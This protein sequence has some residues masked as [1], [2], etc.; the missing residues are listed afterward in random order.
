[1]S[2]FDNV[3]MPAALTPALVRPDRLLSHSG[4]I[5]AKKQLGD[6]YVRNGTGKKVS[7]I[8]MSYMPYA[9]ARRPG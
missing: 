3:R 7:G 8:K 2:R 5:H 1:M 4:E 6:R 9:G